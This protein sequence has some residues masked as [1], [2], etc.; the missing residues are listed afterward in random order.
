MI[1]SPRQ[2]GF[3]LLELLGATALLAIGSAVLVSGLG[4]AMRG[5]VRDEVKTRMA[6][7][8]R[9]LLDESAEVAV[10][11]GDMRGVSD[12]IEWHLVSTVQESLP[13]HVLY[14]QRLT[15]RL[16]DREERFSTLRL[17]SPGQAAQP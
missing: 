13:G 4:D 5:Y 15:L 8:A 11:V 16:G 2:R 1:V 9:S 7:T 6:L 14:H 12:G 17:Q 10:Q 3:T